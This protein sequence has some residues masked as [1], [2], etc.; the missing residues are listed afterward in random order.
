MNIE[1]T[2]SVY[3]NTRCIFTVANI[4]AAQPHKRRPLASFRSKEFI[5]RIDIISPRTW[6]ASLEQLHNSVQYLKVKA[7]LSQL[8]EKDFFLEH[9]KTGNISMISEGSPISGNTFSLCRG[10]LKLHLD[11]ETYERSGLSGKP[12]ERNGTRESL[13][14]W[15][16]SYDLQSPSMQH[17]KRGF[18]R[19]VYGC[20]SISGTP[21]NWVCTLEDPST[22][23]GQLSCV[24]MLVKPTCY[25]IKT[26]QVITHPMPIIEDKLEADAAADLYEW[27]SLVRLGSPRVVYNDSIDPYLSRYSVPDSP[28][29]E[30][31][32]GRTSWDGLLNSSWASNLVSALLATCPE[33][34]WFAISATDMPSGGLGGKSET[35]IL[36]PPGQ[37]SR[38]WMWDI[39]HS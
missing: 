17:G 22:T 27:L 19:L 8:L 13:P 29:G 33:D 32:V 12:D 6:D 20:K 35:T 10:K 4:E 1:S 18:D 23:P 14:K 36:K 26:H 7:T 9:V 24:K 37:S 38:Y 2:P 5:H 11:K 16:V 15:F 3:Q 21:I 31:S 25:Q 34:S 28:P 30:T 39:K